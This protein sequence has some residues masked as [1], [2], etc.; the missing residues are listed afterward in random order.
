VVA[1]G[2]ENRA[3]W[4]RMEQLGADGAQGFLMSRAMMIADVPGWLGSWRLDS[5]PIEVLAPG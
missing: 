3:I 2:V 4:D 5:P 1:E